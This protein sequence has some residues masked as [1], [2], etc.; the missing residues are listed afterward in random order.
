MRGKA[1]AGKAKQAT[2]TFAP[3]GTGV[4]SRTA[5]SAATAARGKV[6]KVVSIL[7]RSIDRGIGS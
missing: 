7:S 1:A 5:R 2:L 4:R 6:Q 3:S